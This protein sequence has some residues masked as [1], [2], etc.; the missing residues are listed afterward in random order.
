M[1]SSFSPLASGQAPAALVRDATLELGAVPPPLLTLS[2]APEPAL[3]AWAF[4]RE[5]LLRGR[6]A[7][8][9]KELLAL[10]A[11]SVAGVEPL[12]VMLHAALAQRGVDPQ[13]LDD[14]VTRGESARLPQRA[15]AVLQ[16]GRKAALQPGLLDEADWGRLRRE[17]LDE[18]EQA[19]LLLAAGAVGLLIHLSRAAS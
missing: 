15:Q 19:E 12:R 10:A 17:G 11:V 7:R 1:S 6:L 9:T 3:A 13:V 14:L 18:A 16:F 5:A 8:T 4:V 2:R